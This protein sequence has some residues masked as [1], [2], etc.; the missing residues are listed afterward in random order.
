MCRYLSWAA[1]ACF[2]V[3]LS[4]CLFCPPLCSRWFAS[5]RQVL[6]Q[7]NGH[8]KFN[9]I[10][11]DGLGSVLTAALVLLCNF[12]TRGDGKL[13]F[14]WFRLFSTVSFFCFSSLCFLLPLVCF[15]VCVCLHVFSLLFKLS[16][17][18]VSHHGEVILLLLFSAAS[19][20]LASLPSSVVFLLLLLG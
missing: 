10:G 8:G 12:D 16:S 2:G 13:L 4:S 1:L 5:L 9:M 14:A 17:D 11:S 20:L 3:V 7:W 18:E 6:L 15:S 19:L